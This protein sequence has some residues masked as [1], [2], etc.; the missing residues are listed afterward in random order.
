MKCDNIFVNG[1]HGEVKIGDLGLATVMQQPTAHSVIGTP[2]FMAP[3]LYD[4]EY[5]ELVDI[6]SFG[7][8]MLEMAT[9]EYPY[10]ECKNAAQIFKK[11]TSGKKPAA[12]DRV[13][14]PQVKQ[15]IEKCLV[16]ASERLSAKD[17]LNDPFL[18][19]SN[20]LVGCSSEQCGI[21]QNTPNLL[22][23]ELD[24][25]CKSLGTSTENS[26]VD[27]NLQVPEFERV[28]GSNKFILKGQKIEESRVSLV[29]VIACTSETGGQRQNVHFDFFLDSDTAL[30]ISKEM[31]EHLELPDNEVVFVADFIDS[32]IMKLVP[33]WKPSMDYICTETDAPCYENDYSSTL[34]LSWDDIS[35]DNNNIS[36]MNRVGSTIEFETIENNANKFDALMD[37]GTSQTDYKSTSSHNEEDEHSEGS[38][39]SFL[40]SEGYKSLSGYTTD[41]FCIVDYVGFKDGLCL[42]EKE[43]EGLKAEIDAINA[44]YKSLLT[45]LL[46]KREEDLENAR[47]KWFTRKMDV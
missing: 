21:A 16:P 32:V 17:L 14:D 13:T 1:N 40:L 8:C 12:L 10:S 37:A 6:Y 31:V 3:E 42:N 24:S 15:F 47:K 39:M 19:C 27:Q 20:M 22:S 29:M 11:V 23:M 18:Q 44:Q 36:K 43:Q 45:E 30:T 34:G 33:G 26:D 25:I 2:E 5:N 7:M 35:P 41:D 38:T 4:E 28:I 9:F 46:R